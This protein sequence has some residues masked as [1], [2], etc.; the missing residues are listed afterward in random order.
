MRLRLRLCLCLRSR[1]VPQTRLLR[2]PC[3]FFCAC[4]DVDIDIDVRH[5]CG[6]KCQYHFLWY[7]QNEIYTRTR[8]FCIVLYKVDLA[9]FKGGRR[10]PLFIGLPDGINIGREVLLGLNIMTERCKQ[11]R[12][13]SVSVSVA[14]AATVTSWPSACSGGTWCLASPMSISMSISMS[15]FSSAT[16]CLCA[17]GSALALREAGSERGQAGAV[18]SQGIVAQDLLPPGPAVGAVVLLGK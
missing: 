11:E 10:V 17:L 3:G 16:R 7:S 5:R 12:T 18:G 8:Q 1:Q 4:I 15:S 2:Y 6:L 13:V 14:V 9:Q